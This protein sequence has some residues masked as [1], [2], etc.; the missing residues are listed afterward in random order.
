MPILSDQQFKLSIFFFYKIYLFYKWY[1]MEKGKS[2][3]KSL[4]EAKET[5]FGVLYFCMTT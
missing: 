3:L 5:M 1:E 4:L 2:E